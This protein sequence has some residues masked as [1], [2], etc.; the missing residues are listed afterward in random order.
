LVSRVSGLTRL[1][2]LTL[3]WCMAVL[4]CSTFP[5]SKVAHPSVSPF[6]VICMP[7]AVNAARDR[8]TVVSHKKQR[9][10]R[11]CYFREKLLAKAEAMV[12][13]GVNLTLFTYM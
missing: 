10:H 4:A 6:S 13:R 7:A 8:K 9:L 3:A 5:K 1:L 2:V 12:S 11:A